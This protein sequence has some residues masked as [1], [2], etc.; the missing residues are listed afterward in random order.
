MNFASP[1]FLLFLFLVFLIYSLLSFFKQI[2]DYFWIK[3]LLLLSSYFFYASWNPKYLL[4]IIFTTLLDYFI[5]KRIVSLSN[6]IKKKQMLSLSLCLNLGILFLFKYYGFFHKEF[7]VFLNY[8][9]ISS[10]FFP[11]LELTLPVGIS[12]YTFQS[13]SYTI[14]VYRGVISPEKSFLNYALYL[15]FFPQLVAGPI[16]TAK[17]FLPQLSA[18]NCEFPVTKIAYYLL[19]GFTKKVIFADRLALTVDLIFASPTSFSNVSVWMG[20]LAYAMQIYCDFSGYSDIARG[21]ALM[22]GIELPENFNLPYLSTSFSEFW[23]RWHISLSGWLKNY[24][25]I[26]LGGNR[27]SALRTKINLLVTMCLGGLWHGASWNFLI[28]GFLHGLLLVIEKSFKKPNSLLT[29][30]VTTGGKVQILQ[31]ILLFARWFIVSILV[32]LLWVP[33]RSKDLQT[34]WNIFEKL[35]FF[36]QEGVELAR[37]LKLEFIWMTFIII[38]SHLFYKYF[39]QKV[40]SFLEQDFSYSSLLLSVILIFTIVL[41]S[42]D[43][44]PFIYFVF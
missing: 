26:S 41:L 39:P 7:F 1:L 37:H 11:A 8:I 15:T 4:L 24:L 5:A 13:L 29:S 44:I 18:L 35:F 25:Y 9:G 40:E 28:W 33:F 23:K 32:T 31:K 34:T 27:I 42:R 22:F 3:I 14:D 38:F 12:F 43:S 21:S 16:V 30:V 17:F 20:V 36:T 19:L 10:T 6:S 2:N